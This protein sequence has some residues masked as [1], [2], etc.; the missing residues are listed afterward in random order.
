MLN[1]YDVVATV[2]VKDL[3]K[4]RTFYEKALGLI[5]QPSDE[6]MAAMV[7]TYGSGG[8]RLLVYVSQFAGTN[9]ATAAMWAVD[10]VEAVARDLKSR[11]VSFERYD[12]PN[13]THVGDVHVMGTRKAAWFKDPDGNVLSIVN[14]S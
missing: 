10:D 13:A 14:R 8:S 5:A 12:M 3:Q 11:G 7:A 6:S 4:A 2:A 1:N 9:Q